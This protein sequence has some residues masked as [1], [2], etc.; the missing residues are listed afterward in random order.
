[1]DAYNLS[2]ELINFW[3]DACMAKNDAGNIIKSNPEV[4]V[5]VIIN[6]TR[7]RVIGCELGETND[8]ILK[9]DQE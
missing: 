7:V 9:L 5:Y 1:M 8:I 2:H 4:E 3:R 6:D